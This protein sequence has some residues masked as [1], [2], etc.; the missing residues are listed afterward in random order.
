MKQL[1]LH[2]IFLKHRLWLEREKCGKCANLRGANID[3]SSWPLWCGSQG[4]KVDLRIIYQLLAHV[5]CLICDEPEFA[6]IKEAI[7]P[8]AVKS[9]IAKDL[10]IVREDGG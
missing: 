4:V 2:K 1:E 6:E 9:H 3:F 7:I 5:A 10:G 8:H